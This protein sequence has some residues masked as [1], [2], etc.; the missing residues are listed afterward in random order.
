[1]LELEKRKNENDE[2][3]FSRLVYLKAKVFATWIFNCLVVC[4]IRHINKNLCLIFVKFKNTSQWNGFLI[5]FGENWKASILRSIGTEASCFQVK[6]A[7]F[8]NWYLIARIDILLLFLSAFNW[9]DLFKNQWNKTANST[10]RNSRKDELLYFTL[11]GLKMFC[12]YF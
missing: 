3:E 11:S 12:I 9:G 4:C 10:A 2:V 6:L 5:N 1:M 7:A 8:R